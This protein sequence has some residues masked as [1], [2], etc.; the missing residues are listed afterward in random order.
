MEF[1]WWEAVGLIGI[2]LVIATGKIFDPL[3][4]WLL[5]FDKETNPLR[6]AGKL[7]SCSMCTGVWIGFVWGFFL[8]D[9]GWWQSLLA[10]GVL[11]ISSLVVDELTALLVLFRMSRANLQKGS[12]TLPELLEARKEMK[13]RRRAEQLEQLKEARLRKRATPRDI[14]ETEADAIADAEVERADAL[15]VEKE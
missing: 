12:M 13:L 10:G 7:L 3:R 4:E 6:L 11:S 9:M 8:K 5:E 2:T 14:S 15:L 1:S